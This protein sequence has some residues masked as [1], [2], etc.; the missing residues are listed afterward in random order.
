M[1]T[2]LAA[3]FVQEAPTV[4]LL[5]FQILEK[6]ALQATIA[7]KVLQFKQ[8]ACLDG[9]KKTPKNQNARFA[10]M[11][12]IALITLQYNPHHVRKVLIVKNQPVKLMAPHYL[13]HAQE[14]H[15]IQTMVARKSVHAQSAQLVDIVPTM[16]CKK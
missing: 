10:K 16:E 15:T 13:F 7:L 2:A 14:A 1:E 6:F 12:L 8:R 11:G 9:I 5:N 3:I 4:Q